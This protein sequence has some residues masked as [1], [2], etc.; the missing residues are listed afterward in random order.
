MSVKLFLDAMTITI[1]TVMS[2]AYFLWWMLTY[3]DEYQKRKGK[4]GN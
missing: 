3:D 4:N 2:G 1:A